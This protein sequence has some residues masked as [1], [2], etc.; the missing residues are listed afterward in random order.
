MVRA[1]ST[2]SCPSWRNRPR[3]DP[4]RVVATHLQR[5]EYSRCVDPPAQLGQLLARPPQLGDDL[6]AA[7]RG[8]V[9]PS[10]RR[11]SFGRRST[12]HC[13]RGRRRRDTSRSARSRTESRPG[14]R[15]PTVMP[16]RPLTAANPYRS[17]STRVPA[18]SLRH[19]AIAL[20]PVSVITVSSSFGSGG[21][22]IAAHVA[23]RLG[24]KLHNRA[25]PAE[26]AQR[27][28]VSL[29]AAAIRDEAADSTV[30]RL[31]SRLSIGFGSDQPIALPDDAYRDPHAFQLH[32]DE[33]VRQLADEG[34]CVLVGRAGAVVLADRSDALHVRFDGDA[35]RRVAQAARALEITSSDAGRRLRETDRAR[36]E[37]WRVFYGRDWRDISCYHL[38]VDSTTLSIESC[39]N[40]VL[41][42]A[43]DLLAVTI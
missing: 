33:V 43:A 26:V 9:R 20:A 29:D 18:S 3:P 34:D 7:S 28:A 24:W 41:T 16:L 6:V 17:S 37:Y 38:A 25:I 42:A 23:A 36:S 2:K 15:E 11:T 12:I 30:G 21:S 39:V 27:L 5:L 1:T 32:S 31:L 8:H 35:S 13:G 22:V 19:I 10:S 14:R 40:L 4:G